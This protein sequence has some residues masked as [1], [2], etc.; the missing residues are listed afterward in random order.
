M[1][2]SQLIFPLYGLAIIVLMGFLIIRQELKQ[3]C[4]QKQTQ[5]CEVH[6][7][8]EHIWTIGGNE[9]LVRQ[10]PHG[11]GEII[12]LNRRYHD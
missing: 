12:G 9:Y 2:L 4:I 8:Q 6:Q 5:W 3:P 1:K 7:K 10:T 11:Q